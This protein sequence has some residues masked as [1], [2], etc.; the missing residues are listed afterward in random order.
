[1]FPTSLFLV[2]KLILPLR[3]LPPVV[4]SIKVKS[5]FCWKVAALLLETHGNDAGRTSFSYSLP[6]GLTNGE[7]QKPHPDW[8]EHLYV[9]GT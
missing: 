4:V 3:L 1:M 8:N 7:K 2:A 5:G 6:P 9:R